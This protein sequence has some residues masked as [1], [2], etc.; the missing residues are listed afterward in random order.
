VEYIRR[1]LRTQYIG[2]IVIALLAAHGIFRAFSLLLEPISFY[3]VTQLVEQHQSVLD[4][5]D[6]LRFPWGNMITATISTAL[7][8]LTAWLFSVGVQGRVDGYKG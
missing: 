8:L 3:L 7:H 1:L 6:S 2:A 4:P 5:T